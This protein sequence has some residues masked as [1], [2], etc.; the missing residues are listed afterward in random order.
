MTFGSNL[1]KP[2][3][4]VRHRN[5]LRAGNSLYRSICPDCDSGVLLMH[6]NLR[7]G[8]LLPEDRC[9][10]CGQEFYYEDID[11]LNGDQQ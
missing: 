5:L 8:K 10:K 1:G 3:R 9:V 7:T 2:T 11:E 4:Y 6:R